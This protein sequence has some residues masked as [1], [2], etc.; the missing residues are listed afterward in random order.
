MATNDK[1]E[2]DTKEWKLRDDY[3]SK[4][5]FSGDLYSGMSLFEQIQTDFDE[6][7]FWQSR[8][9]NLRKTMEGFGLPVIEDY[10]DRVI[11]KEVI[12][13]KVN[14]TFK[15]FLPYGIRYARRMANAVDMLGNIQLRN[16]FKTYR[17]KGEAHTHEIYMPTSEDAEMVVEYTIK[18]MFGRRP[19]GIDEEILDEVEEN[20]TVKEA[21][22][23]Y[24]RR[25][26]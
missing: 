2:E 1:N 17:N 22:E 13:S 10:I 16:S 19:E 12:D 4:R 23:F 6:N 9:G 11:L 21:K 26:Q 15:A 3:I 7:S 18:S 5:V 24:R 25:R 14:D 20:D 8:K